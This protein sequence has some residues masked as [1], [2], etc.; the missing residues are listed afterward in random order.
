MRFVDQPLGIVS[1][2]ML[3]T[4]EWRREEAKHRGWYAKRIK[5]V[6]RG[7]EVDNQR[8]NLR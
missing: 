5:S 2:G 1:L 7:T 4:V 8:R 3:N 6:K